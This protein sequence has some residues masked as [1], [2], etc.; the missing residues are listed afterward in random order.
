MFATPDAAAAG[1]AVS[2]AAAVPKGLDP[3]MVQQKLMHVVE[4]AAGVQH[5]PT[6]WQGSVDFD[7]VL[8]IGLVANDHLFLVV[9]LDRCIYSFG[10]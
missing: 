2:A 4:Q 1:G 10:R 9:N 7:I 8:M 5:R 3:V 6:K